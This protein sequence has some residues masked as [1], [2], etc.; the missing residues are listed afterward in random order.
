MLSIACLHTAASNVAVFDAALAS[1]PV[2]ALTLTHTVRPELLRERDDVTL[3]EAARALDALA[4]GADA[5]L[6]TCSTIG[7]A[8][9][10]TQAPC[11]VLRA[12]AALAEA[13][14]RGGG[15]VSVLYA[16][17]STRGP[18][19]ALFDAAAARHG[20]TV[21][22]LAC[23]GAWALFQAGEVERYRALVAVEAGRAEGRV[24][25]AQ[26]SM[27]GAAALMDRPPLTVPGT[28][29]MAAAR[30]ALARRRTA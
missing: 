11:P 18:T 30:A 15:L 5:V 25:L 7:E 13:A 4:P 3:G 8:V 17:P 6:L 29:L 24:A 21:V 10:R 9:A 2:A 22:V 27:A 12:D 14:T 16:A 23:E 1:L 28:A 20:A 19:L 26:A